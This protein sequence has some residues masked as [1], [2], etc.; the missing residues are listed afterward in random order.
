MNNA[1]E[2]W[3]TT[4]YHYNNIAMQRTEDEV[5]RSNQDWFQKGRDTEGLTTDELTEWQEWR[6]VH[7]ADVLAAAT[8]GQLHT[9]QPRTQRSR[10]GRWEPTGGDHGDN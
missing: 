9:T 7:A 3:E 8:H 10:T 5:R 4:L 6:A 2:T 1:M